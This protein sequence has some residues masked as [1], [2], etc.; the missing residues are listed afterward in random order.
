MREPQ[1]YISTLLLLLV[2]VSCISHAQ[3]PNEDSID[4][5]TKG[6]TA[7][8]RD[9]LSAKSETSDG[10]SSVEVELGNEPKIKFNNI[11]DVL[12]YIFLVLAVVGLSVFYFFVVKQSG[13]NITNF[14]VI[15]FVSILLGCCLGAI[16][17]D[18]MSNRRLETIVREQGTASQQP[19][20]SIPSKQKSLSTSAVDSIVR[21]KV[22][23]AFQAQKH[24]IGEAA[25]GDDLSFNSKWLTYLVFIALLLLT[26]KVFFSV[27]SET[28]IT[29]SMQRSYERKDHLLENL[30]LKE[31]ATDLE[32][33]HDIFEQWY[34]ELKD[35]K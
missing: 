18:R 9:T 23:S 14:M 35:P 21:S 16:L 11:P 20:I 4:G 31:W 17:L 26:V 2:F 19:A 28:R 7:A 27:M 24:T 8:Y 25:N 3:I 32:R 34:K 10:R 6:D 1:F 15:I 13:L 33:M 22:D 5:V 29:Y 12:L 30:F